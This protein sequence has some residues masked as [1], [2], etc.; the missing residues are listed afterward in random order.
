MKYFGLILL[1]QAIVGLVCVIASY[2]EAAAGAT[3]VSLLT[4]VA[5][6]GETSSIALIFLSVEI[7]IACLFEN[8]SHAFI[9]IQ[10][11]QTLVSTQIILS[12]N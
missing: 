12:Q 9:F 1:S 6:K 8:I 11:C 4:C 2:P 10:V 7:I 3:L 5:V